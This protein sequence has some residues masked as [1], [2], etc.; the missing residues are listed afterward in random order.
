MEITNINVIGAANE[1]ISMHELGNTPCRKAR[2]FSSNISKD[3]EVASKARVVSAAINGC[4]TGEVVPTNLNAWFEANFALIPYKN[5]TQ[6]RRQLEESSK[7]V[8]RYVTF[9]ARNIWPYLVPGV[10]AANIELDP[11]V[12]PVRVKP[13]YVMLRDGELKI[14]K[15][16]EAK[17]KPAKKIRQDLALYSM[18][19]YG[20]KVAD[21]LPS[22]TVS[23]VTAEYHFLRK[24]TDRT[25]MSK[26][27]Y[28]FDNDFV[29]YDE[30]GNMPGHN[31]LGISE[32]NNQKYRKATDFDFKDAIDN[33]VNGLDEKN[34]TKT[35]C[36]KCKYRAICKFN[37]APLVLKEEKKKT[38]ITDITLSPEQEEAVNYEKGILRIL[39][40]AG[41]GKTLVVAL[42]VV[43]LL[44]K[45][46]KPSELLL[47]TFSN[48]GAE[49]MRERIVTYLDDFGM[50]DI[51]A[52]EIIITTFNSFG[53]EIVKNEYARFGFTAEPAV[54][55]DIDRS[56][57]IADEL[58]AHEIE[59]LNYR[60]FLSNMRTCE[61]ALDIVKRS[62]DIIKRDN[63]AKGQ[64]KDLIS[65]LGNLSN[66]L[67]SA[68]TKEGR[69]PEKTEVAAQIFDLYEEYNAT[70]V[71]ENLV[72]F[73]DQEVLFERI[74]QEDP[75][76]LEQF[77]IKHVIV[78]E[79]QDTSMKQ[80]ELI[81]KLRNC[82][83]FTSLMVVG[84]DAQA[85]YSFRDTS[86][87]YI[88]HFPEIM[89]EKVDDISLLEN[90]RS[91]PEVIDFANKINALNVERVEKDL[92][93]TRPNGKPVVV[94]GFLTP[95]EEQEYV[96]EGV[97]E[98][99]S[100]GITTAIIAATNEE[101][102][103]MADLLGKEGIPTVM[104]N[105]EKYIDNSRIIATIALANVMR[106]FSDTESAIIYGNAKVGGG[107]MKMTS[108]QIVYLAEEA[109][110]DASIINSIGNP[111]EKM[112]KFFETVSML[113]QNDDEV[114]DSFLK[115]LQ[116]K[117]SLTE[118][119][120]YIDD[121][122]VYGT[123]AGVRR[124]HNYPGVVLTTAHSSKGL[125][126][127]CVYNMITKYST[128]EITKKKV[129][130][131][132]RRLLFVS[133]TRARD[134]LYITCQYISGGNSID[135]YSFNPFLIDAY[136]VMGMTLD[137]GTVITQKEL[138]SA[139]ESMKRKTAAL[140][141]KILRDRI[142][143]IEPEPA[144]TKAKKKS[145]NAK[146]IA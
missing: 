79:F 87:E 36:E 16:K 61:G 34:C 49:E 111:I 22:G 42:R 97:K 101:L 85:I 127:P 28:N 81:K 19:L 70:L 144:V 121:F 110:K 75:Y 67:N 135:G 7:R 90:H 56:R 108:E 113:D 20:R 71:S 6:R 62:F 54:I 139:E 92:I 3:S 43:A 109:K 29:V 57:I 146:A 82:R 72:E 99:Y 73:A 5:E 58:N 116:H 131:E 138:R 8:V 123:T 83:S 53:Y 106:D 132:K 93:A 137:G 124:T 120:K 77:G 95:E 142:L 130:E 27:G 80:M 126:W 66:F 143:G 128:K 96:I 30:N 2:D 129:I 24:D 133:A 114:F 13:S 12:K 140:E 84:D 65:S 125:E 94:Q 64:E 1:Y 63:L 21:V 31:I 38:P 141:R 112:N 46:Y 52:E 14:I 119:M 15:F 48:A 55:D 145:K 11:T 102:Q 4:L 91:T 59:G 118:V 98:H 40:G 78:D 37:E 50:T 41:A 32:M 107:A 51:N 89:G 122:Y 18:L 60:D 74:L 44:Q 33:Y 17:P 9:A 10:E 86:P 134:E 136:H 76:Y 88:I 47:L 105:P 103:K 45:G 39:A 25:A 115:T 69:I 68:K 117:N 35:D 100:N 23:S 104:L 26:D